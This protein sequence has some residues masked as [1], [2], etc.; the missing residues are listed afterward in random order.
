MENPIQ[1]IAIYNSQLE[2]VHKK[3]SKNF[4]FL[5][6]VFFF[7]EEEISGVVVKSEQSRAQAESVWNVA[8]DD[9]GDRPIR[10]VQPPEISLVHLSGFGGFCPR[11]LSQELSKNETKSSPTTKHKKL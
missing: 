1:T 9:N 7:S 8:P 2:N 5:S 3:S 11:V 6:F 10:K 4:L